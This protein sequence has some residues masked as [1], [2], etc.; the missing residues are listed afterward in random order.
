MKIL[1]S[2]ESFLFAVFAMAFSCSYLNLYCKGEKLHGKTAYGNAVT[3][4][5]SF[6]SY[7]QQEI[8]L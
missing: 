4:L 5:T 8:N 3:V 2:I 6:P 1:V 7:C